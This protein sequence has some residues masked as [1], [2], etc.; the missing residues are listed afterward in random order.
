MRCLLGVVR[1]QSREFARK[2]SKR[3]EGSN[4]FFVAIWCLKDGFKARLPPPEVANLDFSQVHM[5]AW[6]IFKSR[7]WLLDQVSRRWRH[8]LDRCIQSLPSNR[9]PL[10]TFASSDRIHTT[11]KNVSVDRRDT[12]LSAGN[13]FPLNSNNLP[14]TTSSL[15]RIYFVIIRTRRIYA[16]MRNCWVR[17]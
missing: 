4:D 7:R 14:L 15:R 9:H 12:L 8:R 11:G 1:C 2:Q 5:K 10:T 17:S 16:M 3:K 13:L 6:L